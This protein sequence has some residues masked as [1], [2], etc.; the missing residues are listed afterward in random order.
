MPIDVSSFSDNEAMQLLGQYIDQAMDLGD[1]EM[2][3]SALNLC[4][5]MGFRVN[6]ASEVELCYFRANAWSVV[7]HAKHKDEA[8]VWLWDQ[9]EILHEIYWL[10]YAV[11]HFS[12]GDLDS[13]RRGQILVNTA[14]ILSHIGRPI[15]AIEY[16]QRALSIVPRFGMALGNL[17][18]GY[19]FYAKLLYDTGHAVIILKSAY[20]LLAGTKE[21]GVIWDNPGFQL[22]QQ[23]MLGR[24]SLISRHIDIGKVESVSLDGFPLGK[25]KTEEKYR[26]W[27]L[28][29]AL[30]VNP[31]ND[32]GSYSIAAQDILHLPDMV[33]N[34]GEPPSL[35]GFYNQ[36]KQEF[37]SARYTLWQGMLAAVDYKRHFSDNDITLSNTLDYPIYGVAI[38]QIKL[39]F[40]S[41]Y[42]LFDK[43]AFFINE[44]W[45]LGV[46]A[47]RVSFHSVWI[48]KKGKKK[49][50]RHE[51]LKNPNLCLRGLY[52]LSK[53]FSDKE[54]DQAVSLGSVMEPDADKLRTIRNHLEHKYLKVHD[55]IWDA[56]KEYEIPP[57]S[58]KLAYHLTLTELTDKTLRL[59]RR[60]REALI[61]LSLAVHQ[62]EKIRAEN[63]TGMT[64]PMT[65]PRWE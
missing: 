16:W 44:Y 25:T 38:E 1:A 55:D 7:R 14:N 8:V 27:V 33:T 17:G 6:G 59:M 30:F 32:I 28:D 48:E 22:V 50:L 3:S 39:A 61:Y 60:A 54:K 24:A 31:L 47:E 34:I 20:D 52:W 18:L 45:D 15:E 53:E 5:E 57:F 4:D 40:R 65:L 2:A 19:E 51:L 12:F 58:D 56:C 64:M 36:L 10:R 26:Q 62:E 35:I 37:V 63:R 46:P 9:E 49:R 23:K 11:R 13:L 29:N 42:S 41:T 21:K 43:I